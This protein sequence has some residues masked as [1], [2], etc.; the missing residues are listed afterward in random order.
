M[1]NSIQGLIIQFT[2]QYERI[3]YINHYIQNVSQL[4]KIV[5]HKE[6]MKLNII[7][8]FDSFVYI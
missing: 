1:E 5:I 6:Q 7:K 8:Y 4:W 2:E 3:L